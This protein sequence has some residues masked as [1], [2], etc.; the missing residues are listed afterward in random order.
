[1]RV[2]L[3]LLIGLCLVSPGCPTS[4]GPVPDD[5]DALQGSVS[6]V[7][8]VRVVHLWGEPYEIGW[9]HGT[10][11]RDE[12][13]A[14]LESTEAI[15][16]DAFIDNVIEADDLVAALEARLDPDHL[17]E[18]HGLHDALEGEVTWE[19]L[20]LNNVQLLLL[21]QYLFHYSLAPPADRCTSFVAMGAATP[22]GGVVATRN[23]DWIEMLIPAEHPTVFAVEPEGKT[24]FLSLNGPGQIGVTTGVSAAGL[25]AADHVALA[26]APSLDGFPVAFAIR[27]ILE[28]SATLDDAEAYVAAYLPPAGAI[29]AVFDGAGGGLAAELAPA[30]TATRQPDEQGRLWITNHF[31]TDELQAVGTTA[32]DNPGSDQRYRRL[33]QLLDQHHGA[34]TPQVAAAIMG[35]RIDPDTGEEQEPGDGTIARDDNLH[36]VVSRP[37]EGLLWVA[38]APPPAS[39]TADYVGLDLAVLFGDSSGEHPATIPNPDPL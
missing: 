6:F 4:E 22:D 35:D 36:S 1:M 38:M 17:D 3:V 11:L 2:C 31:V 24:P 14:G 30:V 29:F 15:F 18:L 12:V 9:A 13:L 7:E 10:L 19:R 32:A 37:G 39:A 25:S 20:L 26:A 33:E 21:Y 16:T 23:L 8:H 34:I 27:T 5:P 28:A